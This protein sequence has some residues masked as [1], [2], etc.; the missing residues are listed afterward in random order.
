MDTG[1]APQPKAEL[2]NV[3]KV[4]EPKQS[5]RT[6]LKSAP[7]VGEKGNLVQ[8]EGDLNMNKM[9]TNQPE[10]VPNQQ[11]PQPL[12]QNQLKVVTDEICLGKWI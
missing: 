3:A 1:Q 12:P 5:E 10:Q 4:T 11:P 2:I 6:D 9:G 7:D 8:H